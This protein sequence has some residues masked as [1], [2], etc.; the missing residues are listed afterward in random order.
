VRSHARVA[1]Q[2]LKMRGVG[3]TVQL[4]YELA[5]RL[6]IVTGDNS[7]GKTFLLDCVWW[8][9]SGT[10]LGEPAT[11]PRDLPKSYPFFEVRVG[12]LTGRPQSFRVKYDW[13]RQ[14]WET[15]P[16]RDILPGL[17]VYARYDGPFGLLDPAARV[18]GAIRSQTESS[19]HLAI[20]SNEVWNGLTRDGRQLCSGLFNRL[21][22][23]ASG[24]AV[25]SAI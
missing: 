22:A 8:A 18:Q 10:W 23:M 11:P 5:E 15:P 24:V 13:E 25:R 4:S 9:L 21:G 3:P 16:Q 14:D 12:T 2:L 6:N 7:L 20:S 17:A 1:L 19:Q